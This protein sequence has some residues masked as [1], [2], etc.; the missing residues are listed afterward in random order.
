MSATSRGAECG[1]VIGV[2]IV[3]LAQQFGYLSLSDLVPAIEA[4][5][6]G[7]I[8]GGVLFALLGWGLGRRYLRRH[9]PEAAPTS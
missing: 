5:L 1:V 6:V 8:V 4:L 2:A 9:P 3:L 7:G